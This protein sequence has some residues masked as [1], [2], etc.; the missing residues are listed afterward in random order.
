MNSYSQQLF[1]L[2]QG[3]Y[4]LCY[5]VL[6]KISRVI[7]L[8]NGKYRVVSKK[9]K[10]LGTYNTRE[11][12]VKR[13]QQVE[14]FKHKKAHSN[15]LT[16]SSLFRLFRNSENKDLVKDFAKIFKKI[17]DKNILNNIEEPEKISLIETILEMSKDND[18]TLTKSAS[19]IEL[20]DPE[21]AGKYLSNIIKFLMQ[22]ISSEKRSKS[23]NNLKKK[24]YYIN[25]YEIASKKVPPS[26]AMGQS[27][28]LLKTILLDHQPK[29]IR[30]ILN[31][32]VRNL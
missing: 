21:F 15:E 3:Y 2:S 16:Y 13:L 14:Y 4:N 9:G 7:K 20:G 28:T 12:A 23:I 8:P 25:E 27:I 22:R 1:I 10:N 17:F 18:L 6:F 5:N 31:S 11:E 30:S 32:I 29:Y 19:A 26:S 24:I